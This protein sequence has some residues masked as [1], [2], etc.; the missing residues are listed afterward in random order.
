LMSTTAFMI[1]PIHPSKCPAQSISQIAQLI[2]LSA[3]WIVSELDN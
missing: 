2:E 1:T 3:K